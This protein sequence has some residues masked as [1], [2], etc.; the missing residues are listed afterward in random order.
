M[1]HTHLGS[2]VC[3]RMG[4]P[5]VHPDMVVVVYYHLVVAAAALQV[6]VVEVRCRV[7]VVGHRTHPR[8]RCQFTQDCVLSGID[9]PLDTEKI[10]VVP[11]A[12]PFAAASWLTVL[13]HA[14][15]A[16]LRAG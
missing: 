3:C 8:N 2:L 1:P 16:Q 6:A 7:Q 13:L 12:I 15:S 14:Q 4:V 11:R 9:V 10:A 5:V